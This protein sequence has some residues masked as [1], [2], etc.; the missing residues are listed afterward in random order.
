MTPKVQSVISKIET[1][2]V[3]P[4]TRYLKDGERKCENKKEKNHSVLL[5]LNKVKYIKTV[6]NSEKFG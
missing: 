2:K 6:E 1:L 5:Y 3:H 4:K